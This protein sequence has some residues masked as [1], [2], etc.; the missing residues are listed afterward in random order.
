MLNLLL[1]PTCP[2]YTQ[3][4]SQHSQTTPSV[5]GDHSWFHTNGFPSFWIS[6]RNITDAIM[7]SG[8]LS[9]AMCASLSILLNTYKHLSIDKNI[10]IMGEK[11][12]ISQATSI[13]QILTFGFDL[14][15]LTNK[16]WL[17]TKSEEENQ[18]HSCQIIINLH[19]KK[20][21]KSR[22]KPSILLKW[23]LEFKTLCK[24]SCILKNRMV[25]FC[26]FKLITHLSTH[27]K[28]KLSLRKQ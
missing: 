22:T 9:T 18:V 25:F 24:M 27:L 14:E 6:A 23:S 4:P 5:K 19:Y 26:L 15:A 16:A 10:G 11:Y 13:L 17:C 7:K 8:Y 2:G 12:N 1:S 21:K 20:K 28:Y 3:H